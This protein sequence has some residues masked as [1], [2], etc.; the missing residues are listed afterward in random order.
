MPNIKVIIKSV[1]INNVFYLVEFIFLGSLIDGTLRETL[2]EWA[3]KESN[4]LLLKGVVNN[5]CFWCLTSVTTKSLDRFTQNFAHRF[6]VQFII[7]WQNSLPFQNN[8][9]NFYTAI[10]MFY[11]CIIIN[12]RK[13]IKELSLF[14]MDKV[15][16]YIFFS[17]QLDQFNW[18]FC[19]MI[20]IFLNS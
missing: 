2:I 5:I 7:N 3:S 15:T 6:S 20:R 9:K 11:I 16:Q 1:L 8:L 12:S 19:K 13:L 14:P 10:E 18:N 17:N 4:I